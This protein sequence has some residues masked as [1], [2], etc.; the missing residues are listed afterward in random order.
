MSERLQEIFSTKHRASRATLASLDDRDLRELES[1]VLGEAHRP[2]R[3]KAMDALVVARGAGAT[4]ALA[5][6]LADEREDLALRAAAASQLGRAGPT[7]EKPLLAALEAGEP[8]ILVAAAGALAK[9]GSPEAMDSLRALADRDDAVGRQARFAATVIAFREGRPG[10]EPPPPEEPLPVPEEGRSR[11]SLRPL[12]GDEAVSALADIRL[13]S[14]GLSLVPETAFRVDCARER[15]LVAVD[16]ERVKLEQPTVA[17]V[18]A[19]RSQSQ[20][21]YSVNW[22]VLAW[23]GEGATFQL[24]VY[25]PSGQQI[26]S[27]IARR[28]EERVSFELGSVVGRGNLPAEVRGS[29]ERGR[30]TALEGAA[31]VARPMRGEPQPE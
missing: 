11:L 29:V 26:L 13:D 7:A 18:V 3:A 24:G 5:L 28:E 15:L 25:R 1:A 23:P 20:G 30:L 27:G 17:G 14:F 2:Y 16:P 10:F 22:L 21:T 9:V 8:T 4:K 12:R 31:G 6:V 19:R